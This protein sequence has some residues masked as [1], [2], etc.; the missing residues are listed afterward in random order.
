MVAASIISL[1]LGLAIAGIGLSE[2]ERA[3]GTALLNGHSQPV[4]L[5]PS[6]IWHSVA[7]GD[8]IAIIQ[9]GVLVLILTPMTRV[10]MT[11]VLF[12]TQRDNVFVAITTVVLLVLVLG[13]IGVGQ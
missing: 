10:A 13:L 1:G 6:A 4:P 12:L 2:Q 7:R 3:D 11:A 9:L 8:P 5:G